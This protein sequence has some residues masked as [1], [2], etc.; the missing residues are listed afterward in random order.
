MLVLA[1]QAAAIALPFSAWSATESPWSGQMN[2]GIAQ[3]TT[4]QTQPSL[5][6]SAGVGLALL[7]APG[8]ALTLGPHML[9]AA[10][11]RVLIVLPAIEF[12][13]RRIA[14][15]PF[16]LSARAGAGIESARAA[17][18]SA[19]PPYLALAPAFSYEKRVDAAFDFHLELAAPIALTGSAAPFAI[20]IFTAGLHFKL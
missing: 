10:S 8:A 11:D 15:S 12:T 18:Q 3:V 4:P 5:A 7:R 17:D 14:D 6:V 20:F 16:S 1:I 13:A 19:R 2:V 9:L